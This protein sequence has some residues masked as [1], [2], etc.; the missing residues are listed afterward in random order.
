[1][2]EL[3]VIHNV[4]ELVANGD[5]QGVLDVLKRSGGIA[6]I[7]GGKIVLGRLVSHGVDDLLQRFKK[8]KAAKKIAANFE[9]T[10]HGAALLQAAI[11]ALAEGLDQERAEAVKKMFLGLAQNPV[12]DSLGRVEQL[13]IMEVTSALTSWE[14]VAVNALERYSNSVFDS[15]LEAK[16]NG[17]RS[18]MER[19]QFSQGLRP[20]QAI[21]QWLMEDFCK[22]DKSRFI[23]LRDSID[24]IAKK[25][26]G[27]YVAGNY[28]ELSR[29]CRFKRSAAFTDFGW[30]LVTH[31][32]SAKEG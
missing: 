24:S 13:E 25:R 32:Y 1:M 11:N 30:K 18:E 4:A 31:L 22:K 26:I 21:D 27:A 20:A 12:D 3:Q 5:T 17:I 10:D 23:G 6:V 28:S 9:E 15:Q 8:A 29:L 19:G 16:W 2:D 7:K 14:V